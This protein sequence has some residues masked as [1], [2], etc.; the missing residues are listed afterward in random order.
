MWE[1]PQGVGCGGHGASTDDRHLCIAAGLAGCGRVWQAHLF[2]ARPLDGPG[3]RA[4]VC[5]LNVPR[6][7]LLEQG[8]RLATAW[9]DT[10][11]PASE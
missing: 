1:A 4:V 10:Q 2:A 8:L 9:T 7:R 11:P 5:R 6:A 3:G